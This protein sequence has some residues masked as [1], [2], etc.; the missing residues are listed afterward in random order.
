M[1]PLIVIAIILLIILIAIISNVKI[2]PQA[3]LC[4]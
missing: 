1:G 4:S 2:V 3:R